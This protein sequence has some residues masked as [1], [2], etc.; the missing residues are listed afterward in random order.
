M[1]TL[2]TDSLEQATAISKELDELNAELETK[3]ARKSE[4]ETQRNNLLGLKPTAKRQ[5]SAEARQKI[6]EAQKRRWSKVNT[7]APAA[8]PVTEPVATAQ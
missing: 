6:S 1:N 8:S 4:L 2:N 5:L 7:D 3:L